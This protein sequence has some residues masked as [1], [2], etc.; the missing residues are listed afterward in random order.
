MRIDWLENLGMDVPTNWDEFV[1]VLEAFTFGDPD[2]NGENDTIGM[3]LPFVTGLEFDY[4]N[5]FIMQNSTGR[6]RRGL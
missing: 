4:Y 3:T 2:G 6:G 1:A 5:R